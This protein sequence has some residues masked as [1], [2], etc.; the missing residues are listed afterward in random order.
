MLSD[1]VAEYERYRLLGEGA[2]AQLPDAALNHVPSLEGNS[3]AM[4][5]RHLSG[6]LESRFTDF[7]SS[8]GEK[9]WRDREEEFAERRYTRPEVEALWAEG[10]RVLMATLA[11]LT[12]EDLS[13]QV[14]I[15]AQ[16]LSVH[17]A[18]CRSLAHVSY[19]VGQLVLL[20][21]ERAEAPW[22]SLSIPRGES[23]AY[24]AALGHDSGRA[25]QADSA[26]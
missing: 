8:D 13:R 10:F 9:L 7:L 2:L 21:R 16:P 25:G 15:R 24:N 4:I 22:R 26:R 18:L 11:Q 19:H 17:A 23:T 3:P 14:T 6:N 20:A 1:F 5:V 12:E